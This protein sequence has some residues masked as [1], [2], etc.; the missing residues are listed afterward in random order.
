MAP[1][2][3]RLERK[4]VSALMQVSAETEKPMDEV[5]KAAQKAAHKHLNAIDGNETG[6]SSATGASVAATAATTIATASSSG[7]ATTSSSRNA[8][9][10]NAN[11][12]SANNSNANN[13]NAK[14]TNASNASNTSSSSAVTQSADVAGGNTATPPMATFRCGHKGCDLKYEV[15]SSRNRVRQRTR[16]HVE[17][18]WLTSESSTGRTSMT[19]RPLRARTGKTSDGPGRLDSSL[20]CDE[21]GWAAAFK[22]PARR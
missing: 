6:E 3:T 17:H 16:R 5:M 11:N 22:A 18:S 12:T 8:H 9:N 1:L 20:E 13:A 10:S 4:V 19:A 14:S 7:N 21:R 15:K 2:P